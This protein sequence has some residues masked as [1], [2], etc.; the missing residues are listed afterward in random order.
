M[1]QGDAEVAAYR[2]D[3]AGDPAAWQAAV[4]AAQTAQFDPA[5][6]AARAAALDG[7]ALRCVTSSTL[8]RFWRAVL[9]Q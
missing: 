3:V 4:A 1:T 2:A 6:T 5:V 7:V 8:A 9:G